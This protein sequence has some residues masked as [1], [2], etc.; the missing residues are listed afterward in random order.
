MSLTI[1]DLTGRNP[2]VFYELALRHAIGKPVIHIKEISETI[3]FDVLGIRIIDIDSRYIDDIEKTKE[4]IK[5]YI[6]TIEKNPKQI[7]E[8][9]IT[10]S[11][12]SITISSLVNDLK[13]IQSQRDTK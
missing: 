8:N 2:N 11:K 9:P 7:D 10:I 6:E 12:N 4:T 3:P 5:D 1:A 13:N